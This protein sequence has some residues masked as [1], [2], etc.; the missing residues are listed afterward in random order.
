MNISQSKIRTLS[1]ILRSDKIVL[2][3]AGGYVEDVI[4]CL[5]ESRITAVLDSSVAKHGMKIGGGYV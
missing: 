5:G 2:W 4:K 3:G 1:D